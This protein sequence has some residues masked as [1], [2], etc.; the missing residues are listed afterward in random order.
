M[1]NIKRSF[2]TVA[3]S[4]IFILALSLS[5]L[6][7]VRAENENKWA[8]VV[9]V[10]GSDTPH[11]DNDAQDFAGVLQS[12]YGFPSGQIILLINGGATKD[13]VLSALETVRDAENNQS[14]VAIFIS[15][16]GD[17]DKVRLYDDW[18]SGSELSSILSQY[19]SP[20]ILVVINA[21]KSGSWLYIG[22]SIRGILI[23]ACAADEL[24]Y[25]VDN[26]QNTVFVYYFVDQGMAQGKADSNQDG[27]VT[28]EEAFYYAESK[29]N[30]PPG[31]LI[32]PRTHPQMVDNYAGDFDLS[33]PVHAPWFS[34]LMAVLAITV[35]AYAIYTKRL[36]R[37]KA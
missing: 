8:V 4:A 22:S 14:V 21:C 2:P 19:E 26:F 6:P 16:H 35:S 24:T 10:E 27:H 31:P 15:A 25:D 17:T 11:L 20:K 36:G 3:L 23:T 33:L 5:L 12:L 18:L 9:G 7:A 37:K 28:V 1:R 13:A 30:P 34:N 32:V 29:C